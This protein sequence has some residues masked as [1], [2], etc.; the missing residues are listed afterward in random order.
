MSKLTV[1]AA[2]E[3]EMKAA[4]NVG[5]VDECRR[6][7]EKKTRRVEGCAAKRGGNW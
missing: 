1:N 7:L 2:D 3:E 4:Y 6:L 5:G